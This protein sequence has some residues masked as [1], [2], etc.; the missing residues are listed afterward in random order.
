MKKIK[1]SIFALTIFFAMAF[2]ASAQSMVFTSIDGDKV[3]L[4]AEKGKVVVMAIGA[5]W[6]PLSTTQAETINK[7]SDRYNGEDVVFYFIATD[8]EST[9]SKNYASDDD[10]EKFKKRNKL[11]V[12]IL[13]DNN[14]KESIEKFK[15][16]QLP[17]FIILD[18]EGKMSGDPITGIDPDGEIDTADILSKRI[19]TLL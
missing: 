18:K 19:D 2:G 8:S 7:L 3:D 13:R 12:T 10:I 9:K 15:L 16:D 6:L 4:E 1:L 11:S 14:G 5:S 17:A